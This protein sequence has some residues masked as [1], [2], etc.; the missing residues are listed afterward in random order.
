MGATEAVVE[1]VK[2]LAWPLAA[3]G[4]VMWL[5]EPLRDI[6]KRPLARLKG[7]GF[8]AEWVR[9]RVEAESAAAAV[10]ASERQA[11]PPTALPETLGQLAIEN[12]TA[13]I[14][15]AYELVRRVLEDRLRQAEVDLED[16]DLASAHRLAA[17]AASRGL[18]TR[19]SVE[20][21]QGLTVLRNLVAHSNMPQPDTARAVEYLALVEATLYSFR[22]PGQRAD[23]G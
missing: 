2:A 9:T 18:I 15:E 13:A 11:N 20:S 16:V 21:V 14:L 17:I 1:L 5:R 7:P 22:Q 12:P 10:S 4:I 8:E 19:Q 3:L 6:L 23:E